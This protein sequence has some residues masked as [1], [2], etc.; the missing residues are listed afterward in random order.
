MN[1]VAYP[2]I[3]SILACFLHDTNIQSYVISTITV[4][5]GG[6]WGSWG[7]AEF[8][9]H[10]YAVGFSLKIEPYQGGKK[11]YDDT[12]LNGIRLVCS[13]GTFISSSVGPWGGWSE[14]Q[15]CPRLTKMISFSLRVERPQI[16]GDDSACSNIQFLCDDNTTILVGNSHLWGT[17][18]PWSQQCSR[19]ICGIQTKVE[20]PQDSEDDTALNDVKFFC[21]P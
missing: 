2:V 3:L 5:N 17:F 13:D 14:I 8:C 18:G 6:P 9:S 10:G 1:C 15:Y 20:A 19:F 12:S 11:G 7:K 4:P 21:C 16:N